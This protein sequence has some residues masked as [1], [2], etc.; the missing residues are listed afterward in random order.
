VLLSASGE[1]V[2]ANQL[3]SIALNATSGKL[4]W[5]GGCFGGDGTPLV[6]TPLII[7]VPKTQLSTVYLCRLAS[8]ANLMVQ[9][10][11][12]AA[13]QAPL[14]QYALP[15]ASILASHDGGITYVF[16]STTYQGTG[17]SSRLE[18]YNTS[19]SV[20]LFSFHLPQSMGTVQRY[21]AATTADG[22]VFFST[23]RLIAAVNPILNTIRVYYVRPTSGPILLNDDT[24]MLAIDK[25]S[26]QC[27]GCSAIMT[28]AVS[29]FQ[30]LVH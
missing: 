20:R 17:I 15:S 9:N 26:S 19:T 7:G 27:P 13:L 28:I 30:K 8:G 23:N 22:T 24:C 11:G 14:P 2:V 1:I 6:G 16:S 4:L 3:G 25:S 29:R 12:S 10:R 18:G 21:T 5:R